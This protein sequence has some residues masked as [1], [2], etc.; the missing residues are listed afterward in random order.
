MEKKSSYQLMN[1][2]EREKKVW[3]W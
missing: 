1:Q 2:E 3:S